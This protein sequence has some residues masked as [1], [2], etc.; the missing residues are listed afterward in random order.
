MKLKQAIHLDDSKIITKSNL[1]TNINFEEGS[2]FLIHKPL[3]WTSFD[4]VNKVKYAIRHNKEIKKIK[5]GHA[6]TLDPMAE[7]LLIVCTGKY[8]KLLDTLGTTDK[9]YRAVIK[10]GATT[11]CYD[12]E[13]EEENIQDISHLTAENIQN[14]KHAFEGEQQQVPPIYS[15]IKVKGQTA[16]K[17]ARRGEDIELKARTVTISDILFQEINLPFATFDVTV[18]KGTYIRS[19]AHDMG[20]YLGVGA[21]LYHLL[22]SRVGS[23]DVKDAISI[24]EAVAFIKREDF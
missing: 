22:R 1:P 24:E 6:G 5:V 13:C 17:V 16:Y 10:L 20:K 11:P 12:K 3:E 14:L 2:L 18:S 7:G 4:I 15:A 23:F 21:Y 8:T 9:A 19:L